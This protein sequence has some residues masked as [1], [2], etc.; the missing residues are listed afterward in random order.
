[1]PASAPPVVAR[2]VIA[3]QGEVGLRLII[4]YK[5]GKAI[6]Q[7]TLAA[8]LPVLR[9][10]G[11]TAHLEVL[12]IHLAKNVVHHWTAALAKIL[13]ALLTPNHLTLISL[14][15][16][17]DAGMSAFEAWSLHRRFRWAPWLVV[18]AGAGL[19]PAEIFE[20]TRHPRVGRFMI[21]LLNL[22]IIVYLVRRARRERRHP[23]RD[24]R[25]A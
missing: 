22:A 6:V 4:A 3:P 14:A 19:V 11:V 25:A 20:L 8:V 13:A 21:L 2:A 24:E 16:A 9:G 1:M 12:A 15:L 5:V 17:L 23:G 18:I 10:L 7:A